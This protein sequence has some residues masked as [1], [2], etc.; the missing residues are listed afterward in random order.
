MAIAG[1]FA[2]L[3]TGG[4]AGLRILLVAALAMALA[5]PSTIGERRTVATVLLVDVSASIG[6]RQLAAA[7]KL[8]EDA[9]GARHGDDSCAW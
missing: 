9:R 2:A 7:R 6:D 1:R 3:R 4:G 8:V 5:R